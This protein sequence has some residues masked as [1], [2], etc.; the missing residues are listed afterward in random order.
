VRK[1]LVL[2]F[3]LAAVLLICGRVLAQTQQQA[4][5]NTFF[6]QH[7]NNPT[8]NGESS[9]P[10]QVTYGELRNWDVYHVSWPDIERGSLGIHF[11]FNPII[12]AAYWTRCEEIREGQTSVAGR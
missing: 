12:S 6:G 10:V 1:V 11:H 2:S 5:P 9:Y 4:I 7:V 3:V 8:L